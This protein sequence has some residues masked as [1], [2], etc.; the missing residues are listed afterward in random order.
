MFVKIKYFVR[1]G[2]RTEIKEEEE[3]IWRR[4]IRA[5]TGLSKTNIYFDIFVQNP[6]F[7]TFSFF[8]AQNLDIL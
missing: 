5:A 1:V 6:F 3:N 4:K 7:S 2:E 8:L